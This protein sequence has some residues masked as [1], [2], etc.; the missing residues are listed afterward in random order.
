VTAIRTLNE[1]IT[2]QTLPFRKGE[3]VKVEVKDGIT[4]VTIDGF[5]ES[6]SHGALVDVFFIQVGFSEAAADKAAFVKAAQD[7]L[8]PGAGEFSDMD[9]ETLA[10]GPS[11]IA[12]GGW[13]GDQTQA[14]LFMALCAF[15]LGASIITPATLGITDEEPANEL[16]GRGMVMVQVPL[17]AWDA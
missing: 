14:L 6:P 1:V 3:E 15:H 12:L 7:A 2:E 4:V 5:P 13:L 10:Q 8:Q 11:Y 9:A 16:A 17:T